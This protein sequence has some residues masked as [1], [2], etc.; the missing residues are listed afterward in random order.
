MRPLITY[1]ENDENYAA[2]DQL[3]S[4]GRDETSMNKM[5]NRK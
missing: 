1:D 3:N 2:A 5:R 4:D